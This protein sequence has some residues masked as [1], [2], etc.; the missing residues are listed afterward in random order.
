MSHYYLNDPNLK[1]EPKEINY[2]YRNFALSF[3]TDAGV[4]SKT[5]VDFGTHLLLQNL[6]DALG[7]KRILDLGCG[8]GIIG[9]SLAKAYPDSFITLVDVNQRALLLTRLNAENNQI[10]NIDIIESNLYEK[11]EGKYDLII[12]NPPFRA[13]KRV[14]HQIVEEAKEHLNVQ[15]SLFIVVQKKQGAPS[16]LRKMA[17]VFIKTNVVFSSKGYQIIKAE[18]N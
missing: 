7:K 14:V 6:P 8:Y 4:F 9:L 5:R 12:S 13:G 2:N 16:L 18:N 11:I 17:E 1:S 10:E 15:G 3:R